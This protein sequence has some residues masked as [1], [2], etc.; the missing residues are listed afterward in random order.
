MINASWQILIFILILLIFD[1][2][3]PPIIAAEVRKATGKANLSW[4][5]VMN[6]NA[7]GS[8][9]YCLPR[10]HRPAKWRPVA[11]WPGFVKGSPGCALR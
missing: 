9:G 2:L 7:S 6:A 4:R 11:S 5:E 3:M 10:Q 1:L 8:G